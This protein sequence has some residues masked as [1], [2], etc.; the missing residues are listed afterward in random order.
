MAELADDIEAYAAYLNAR[1]RAAEHFDAEAL[2]EFNE[3][4]EKARAAMERSYLERLIA[5]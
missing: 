1:H 3:D 4:V 5:T 2:A